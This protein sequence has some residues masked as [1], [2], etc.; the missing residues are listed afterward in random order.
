MASQP[1]R[2][3]CIVGGGRVGG[4][5]GGNMAAERE[6]IHPMFGVRLSMYRVQAGL[7]QDELA[8]VVEAKRNRMSSE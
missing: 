3:W 2:P 8:A 4:L 5:F 7:D 1:R 6:R